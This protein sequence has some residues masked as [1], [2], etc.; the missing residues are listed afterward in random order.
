MG[1]RDPDKIYSYSARKVLSFGVEDSAV[2]FL[3][4]LERFKG[5][6]GRDGLRKVRVKRRRRG[7]FQCEL[8]QRK[9]GGNS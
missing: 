9:V 1:R 3:R 6:F 2:P 7:S 4:I 5:K 8:V